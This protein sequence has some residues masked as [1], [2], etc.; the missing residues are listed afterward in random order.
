MMFLF[1]KFAAQWFKSG[2]TFVL[3]ST[4]LMTTDGHKDILC[5]IDRGIGDIWS[6]L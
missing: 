1:L 2:Q 3:Q 4:K 5:S 6:I